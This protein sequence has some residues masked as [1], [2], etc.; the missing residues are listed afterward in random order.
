M[1]FGAML[2]AVAE[3]EV[4][5]VSAEDDSLM[6]FMLDEDADAMVVGVP[7]TTGPGASIVEGVAAGMG[8][9]PVLMGGVVAG[10]A[11][12]VGAGRGI[13]GL[14]GW[15][16]GEGKGKDLLLPA[17]TTAVGV[18]DA[19]GTTTTGVLAPGGTAE[20]EPGTTGEVPG[21]AAAEQDAGMEVTV[22]VTVSL[23]GEKGVSKAPR[24]REGREEKE[25]V[26][27]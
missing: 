24:G 22:T 10:A 23:S 11:G 7:E 16:K 5:E 27:A 21:R 1:P 2:D 3:A 17:G 13:S 8:T 25:G 20:A 26:R 9:R 12:V 19:P 15:G 6:G 4:V 14:M 18:P